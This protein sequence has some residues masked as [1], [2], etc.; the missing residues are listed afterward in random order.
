M[1]HEGKFNNMLE[2]NILRNS[3]QRYLGVL[4]GGFCVF[5]CPDDT[6]APC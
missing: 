2:I 5:E 1:E 6:P 4:K 3:F